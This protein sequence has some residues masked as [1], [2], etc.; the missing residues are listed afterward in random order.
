MSI[1]KKLLNMLEEIRTYE[2][3]ARVI[4]FDQLTI[5]PREG[6]KAS[7]EIAA[8]LRSQAFE[9]TQAPALTRA[10]RELHAVRDTLDDWERALSDRLYRRYL[11]TM[12]L[13]PEE[14]AEEEKLKNQAYLDWMDAREADDYHLFENSL[15]AL[16]KAEIRR[17]LLFEDGTPEEAAR[18]PYA[19]MLDE[20]EPGMTCEKL[21]ALFSE[22]SGRIRKLMN[23]IVDSGKQM[24]SDFLSRTVTDEQQDAFTRYLI[25]LIGFDTSRGT[26]SYSRHPFTDLLSPGDV[27]FTTRYDKQNFSSNLY[28]VLHECGHALFEQLQPQ[29]NHLCHIEDNKSMG[30]H[31]AVSRFYENLIGRSR[32]FIHLIYPKLCEIFPQVFFDVGEEDLYEAVNT[33]TPSLIRMDADELTYTLHIIIR[34]Q[35]EKEMI[36]GSLAAADLPAAWN[37]AY[38]DFLGIQPEHDAEGILQESHWAESFGYFPTYALGNFYSAMILQAIRSDMDLEGA[39]EKGDFQSINSWMAQHVFISADRLTAGEWIRE[40]CGR[41]LTSEDYLSYLEEK[42]NAVYRLDESHQSNKYFETYRRHMIRIRRLSTLQLDNV[43]G[44]DAY[45]SALAD[46]FRKIGELAKKNR[47]VMDEVIQPIL[48]SREPLPGQTV[49]EVQEF[50][51]HLMDAWR[52]ENIDLPVMSLLSQRMIRDADAKQ[53][54]NYTVRQLDQEIIACIA[55]VAETRRIISRPQLAA[56]LRERGLKALDKLLHYLEK[57]RFLTLSEESRELVLINSRYGNGLFA[58]LL[59]LSD[60]ERNLRFL[61]LSRSISLAEEPFYVEATPASDWSYHLYR[62]YDYISGFDEYDNGIG[63]KDE[64]LKK[65]AEGADKLEEIWKGDRNRFEKIDNYLYIHAHTLR[66]YMHSGRIDKAKYLEE[67]YAI[68]ETRDPSLFDV[69]SIRTNI[70]LPCDYIA[71]L[72]PLTMTESQ[73]QAADTMYREIL[74]YV[75]RMPKT[76]VFFELMDYYAPLIFHFVE[77][78]GSISFEEMILRSFAAFHPPTYIHSIM[79]A[80]IS[81]CLTS[82]LLRTMP[83]L[84]IG[85]CDCHDKEEVV[86]SSD[87]IEHFIYHAALC[88]DFGKL[89]IIDTIFMYGRALLNAEFDIIRQH[90]ELGAMLLEKHQSTRPYADVA[91]GHHVWYNGEGGYPQSFVVMNSPLRTA[92]LIIACADCM[93]AATDSVG[94]SYSSGI[95]LDHFIKEVCDGAGT[96]YA[97]WLPGLLKQPAVHEDLDRLLTSGRQSTYRKTWLLL[98]GVQ[99]SFLN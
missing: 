19:R 72:D 44:T 99:D 85:M 4:S 24:R 40:I 10:V 60:E 2:H 63:Y 29:R 97:P 6:R 86:R 7:G 93:D 14:A 8:H 92:I 31:E 69:D 84:F 32:E 81:R 83:E 96:R 26:F 18:S 57:D 90:P 13:S 55:L 27:R 11:H 5:C 3:A 34:Y 50:S 58:S 76:G 45:R 33:V 89:I 66:N 64:E 51:D 73:Y 36:D 1:D 78:P 21:D 43:T 77:L 37:K 35:L 59:P 88:H 71:A 38:Q 79:V 46:N 12:N 98:R 94:R 15:E 49:R 53:D 70:E 41:E 23:A 56:S 22:A 82:H 9:L 91:R 87:R 39:I 48:S 67:L 95:T 20:N 68:Y 52:H 28:T 30:M 42:Y 62:C 47:E 65:I 75:L 17:V 16:R 80:Q 74:S 61:L 54:D 25:S